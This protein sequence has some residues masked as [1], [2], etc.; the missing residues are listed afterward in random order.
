LYPGAK[1]RLTQ[2]HD[3]RHAY[4]TIKRLFDDNLRPQ[5]A[6]RG[7]ANYLFKKSGRQVTDSKAQRVRTQPSVAISG[8]SHRIRNDIEGLRALAVLSVLINHAFPTVLPGGFAGVDIF[9]VISGYLIGRHLLQDIQADRFS[10]LGFYAKRA[11]RI[12]PALAL[13][14]ISVWGVGWAVFSAQ[15]FAALGRHIAAAALFSNNILLWSESGYF[16]TAAVNKPLLHLWSLG[17]EEQFYLLVPTLLWVSTK[18][19]MGSIR[20]IA[21]LGALSLLATIVLSNCDDVSS[22]YLLHTRFWEL[23]TGVILAQAELKMHAQTPQQGEVQSVVKRDVREI[24]LYSFTVVFAAVLVMGASDARWDWNAA[25]RDGGLASAIVVAVAASFLADRYARREAWNQLRSQW[26]PYGA[27]FAAASS[28]AGLAITSA[29]LA[30]LSSANWPGAQTLFPVLGATL[31]IAAKPGALINRLLAW[32]P[33]VFIGGISYPLYLWHWPAIVI[34][35]LLNPGARAYEMLIPLAISLVL[36]WLTK[37][38]LEDPVRF[39]TVG[40]AAFRPPSLRPVIGGLGLAG[41]LGLSVVVAGGIPSRFPP[42]LRAV[43]EWPEK[44]PSKLKINS[45]YDFLASPSEFSSECMPAKRSGVPLILLW[46][47]S[48]A[49]H[50]YPGIANLRSTIAF[51]IAQWTAPNCPP[52]VKPLRGEPEPCANRRA[53]ALKNLTQLNPDTIVLGCAWERYVESGDTPDEIISIVSETIR[54]LKNRGITRIVIF[55]PGH[56]WTTSLPIDLFRFMVKARS[57][58]I[59]E[60]LGRVS[61]EIWRLDTA[62]ADQAVVENVQY[63][64]IIKYFCSKAGCLTVGDRTLSRPDLLYRDQDHLTETGSKLLIRHSIH[65]LF[66]EN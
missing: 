36:A 15:E 19:A 21:R 5:R 4:A 37:K 51:D 61:D 3:E 42:T 31:L 44:N 56:L 63:V 13:V 32:K 25:L 14:L 57:N 27:R 38:F 26:S 35:R 40:T 46:G 16:D 58:E 22:F 30:T 47:D 1:H 9:F 34:W 10:I 62:M 52:T 60:R 53:T 64:S 54:F 11:R 2:Q 39:G 49:A 18:R 12:F 59:P 41:V 66:G 24:L 7:F 6:T 45:C 20:W 55:G 50:L 29:S 28:I 48:H 23:A 8:S 65:Q 17:I 33:L 43:A